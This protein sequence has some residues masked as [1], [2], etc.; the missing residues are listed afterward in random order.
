MGSNCERTVLVGAGGKEV[1]RCAS[2]EGRAKP[3]VSPA[4]A[5]IQLPQTIEEVQTIE[6]ATYPVN[7]EFLSSLRAHI[8][9]SCQACK[10]SGQANT[11]GLI[12]L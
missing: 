3:P 5:S 12:P 2:M 6:E 4:V 7:F 8:V 1:L 11:I 9:C 10:G